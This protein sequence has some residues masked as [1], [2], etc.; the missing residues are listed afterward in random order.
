MP[1]LCRSHG[2]ETVPL[3][4]AT[5]PPASTGRFRASPAKWR[6]PRHCPDWRC[7]IRDYFARPRPSRVGERTKM[8]GLRRRSPGAMRWPARAGPS[9]TCVTRE[10]NEPG[11]ETTPDG[12]FTVSRV[13]CLGSCGTAPMMQIN[14]DY[15]ED[16]T[17]EKVDQILDSLK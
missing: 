6:G 11:P 9:A 5:A 13:E 2:L 14:F 8:P 12:K 17:I 15:A 3:K 16:L 4:P 10:P 1:G 7:V